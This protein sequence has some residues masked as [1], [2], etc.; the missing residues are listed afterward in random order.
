MRGFGSIDRRSIL[1]ARSACLPIFLLTFAFLSGGCGFIP[2]SV[3]VDLDY[4]FIVAGGLSSVQPEPLPGVGSEVRQTLSN[5]G[6]PVDR[7]REIRVTRLELVHLEPVCQVQLGCDLGF[8]QSLEVFVDSP[9]LERKRLGSITS[10]G[11][12]RI[13]EMAIDDVELSDYIR[14]ESMTFVAHITLD[15]RPIQDVHLEIRSTLGV[16]VRV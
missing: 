12:V 16:D 10:P 6:V 13:I 7:V 14:A 3:D 1:G 9:G 4:P 11:Q 15:G 8:I 2:A 5:E